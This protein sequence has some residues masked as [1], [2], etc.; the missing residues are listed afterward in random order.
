MNSTNLDKSAKKDMERA[1]RFCNTV[2][3]LIAWL[4]GG[5]L[6]LVGLLTGGFVWLHTNMPA[7]TRTLLL[8][9]LLVLTF[10][11]QY[12]C[13]CSCRTLLGAIRE[14]EKRVEESNRAA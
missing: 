6:F 7:S 11:P 10:Y 9:I 3:L 1:T 8:G 2:L 5:V 14:L 12:M 13:L 4:L